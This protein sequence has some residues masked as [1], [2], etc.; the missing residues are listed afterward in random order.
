MLTAFHFPVSRLFQKGRS[1][2]KYGKIPN[3]PK[4]DW[5]KT[6]HRKL[7]PAGDHVGASIALALRFL[8]LTMDY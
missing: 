2:E 3:H 5:P 1:A 7:A 8:R 4:C 6:K